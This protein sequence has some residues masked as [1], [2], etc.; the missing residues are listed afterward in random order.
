MTM[1]KIWLLIAALVLTGCATRPGEISDNDL[2]WSTSNIDLP[3][4]QVEFNLITGFRRCFDA[5]PEVMDSGD[6]VNFDVYSAG[7]M[8]ASRSNVVV[9]FI[10]LRKDGQRTVGQFGVVKSF[11]D[12]VFGKSGEHRRLWQQWATGNPSCK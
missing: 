9:G 12:P 4:Q 6:K 8:G 3:L 5:M 11:D 7:A 10:R 1:N 2:N